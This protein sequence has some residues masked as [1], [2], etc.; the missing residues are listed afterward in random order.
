MKE[1]ACNIS[2]LFYHTKKKL[3][4]SLSRRLRHPVPKGATSWKEKGR[5]VPKRSPRRWMCAQRG[6]TSKV[7]GLGGINQALAFARG[8]SW[9]R[10]SR[11]LL[12]KDPPPKDKNSMEGRKKEENALKEEDWTN[13][14]IFP[15]TKAN[16]NAYDQKRTE[17]KTCTTTSWTS[18]IFEKD[19]CANQHT[20]LLIVVVAFE[21]KKIFFFFC[22]VRKAIE[23]VSGTRERDDYYSSD[24]L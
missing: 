21:K 17:R 2:S 1:G 6:L 20:L 11:L 23:Q 13:C 5:S 10:W 9:M 4:S 14:V 12:T 24:I 22:L 8:E 7:G 3:S 18:L 15:T 19:F 16:G